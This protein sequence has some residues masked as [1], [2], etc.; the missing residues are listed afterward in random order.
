MLI[1]VKKEAPSGSCVMLGIEDD[2][3][4]FGNW[5]YIIKKSDWHF[6]QDVIDAIVELDNALKIPD[7]H[8]LE[9]TDDGN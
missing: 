4:I 7:V 9:G 1:K 2:E 3:I 5:D 8:K 6:F